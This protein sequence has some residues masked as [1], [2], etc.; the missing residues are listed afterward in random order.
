MYAGGKL[1][2]LIGDNFYN[3]IHMSLTDLGW[4]NPVRKHLPVHLIPEPVDD[5]E[6]IQLNTI[7]ISDEE[8]T[9]TD[10]ELGS[11][12]AEHRL[13]YYI[14]V[15]AESKALGRHISGDLKDILEGRLNSI[16]RGSPSFSVMDLSLATPTEMFVCQIENVAV[17]RG[18][19]YLK[20]HQ[21][22]WYSLMCE[23]VFSFQSD[24]D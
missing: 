5:N 20:P 16:H 2:R 14:D 17:E 15:Y 21:K 9:T 10:I 6:T 24:L 22:F 23:L 12:L 7:S 1:Y 18:R 3:M 19:A 13:L 8:I 4:F 11:V